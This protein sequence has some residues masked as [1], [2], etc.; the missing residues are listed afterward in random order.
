MIEY[1]EEPEA[2]E[3]IGEDGTK[4]LSDYQYGLLE[5]AIRSMRIMKRSESLTDYEQ[6][7]LASFQTYLEHILE[8]NDRVHHRK[9][10][11]KQNDKG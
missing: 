7:R 2:I 4:R 11:Y 9:L 10:P 1:A 6:K 5:N 8:R 3:A